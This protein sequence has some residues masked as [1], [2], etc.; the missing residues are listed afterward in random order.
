MVEEVERLRAKAERH[1][2]MQAKLSPCRKIELCGPEASHEISGSV[3][4]CSGSWEIEGCFVDRFVARVLWPVQIGRLTGDEIQAASEL[5]PC[6]GVGDEASAESDGKGRAGIQAR[7]HSPVVE[8]SGR[9]LW[10]R[11][12]RQVPGDATLQIVSDVEVRISS[13][14]W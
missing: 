6:C 7:I 14:Q 12:R 10:T 2:I 8:Q 13:L 1:L 4:R 11:N 5:A 9:Q 3:S